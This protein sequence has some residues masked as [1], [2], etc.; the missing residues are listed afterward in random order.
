MI[1][2]V[3]TSQA[4]CGMKELVFVKHTEGIWCLAWTIEIFTDG[5]FGG[6]PCS[7]SLVT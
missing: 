5:E 2:M 6:V 1:M 7:A 3:L 4:C